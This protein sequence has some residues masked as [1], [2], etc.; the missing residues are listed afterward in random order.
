MNKIIHYL[1][2]HCTLF[3]C[4]AYFPTLTNAVRT[5]S[6]DYVS[7]EIIRYRAPTPWALLTEGTAETLERTIKRNDLSPIGKPYEFTPFRGGR[8]RE[9]PT[10]GGAHF[11]QITPYAATFSQ[12]SEQEEGTPIYKYYHIALEGVFTPDSNFLEIGEH[13]HTHHHRA[14]SYTIAATLLNY[15]EDAR[16]FKISPP[17]TEK[18]TSV[19]SG[20]EFGVNGTLQFPSGGGVGTSLSVNHSRT[21]NINDVEIEC[22]HTAEKVQWDFILNNIHKD[23]HKTSKVSKSTFN[24]YVQWIWRVRGDSEEPLKFK[25]EFDA[26]FKEKSTIHKWHETRY[27]WGKINDDDSAIWIQAPTQHPNHR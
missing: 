15:K 14:N 25:I 4:I 5:C 1:L 20:I 10:R 21:Y 27:S 13:L 22:N 17:A 3:S 7:D 23:I 11:Y 26:G 12:K 8:D 16:I 18:T 9:V 19:T 24:P 6:P 2:Y